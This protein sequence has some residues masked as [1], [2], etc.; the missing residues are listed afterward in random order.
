MSPTQLFSV[1]IAFTALQ[2]LSELWLS[3]HNAAVVKARGGIEFGA[4]HYPF[5]VLVHLLW[6]AAMIFEFTTHRHETVV[7]RWAF[8]LCWAIMQPLRYWAIQTLGVYWNTRVIVQPGAPRITGG[9]YR[10]VR[11]PNY[12]IVAVELVALPLA[13]HLPIS[14]V[15]GLVGHA[16]ILMARI[17]VENRALQQ[18]H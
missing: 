17:P 12:W 10:F 4:G 18:L 16:A 1:L 5:M 13:F 3:R 7:I 14:A 11:H 8:L 2:R 15:L 9:P 6:F